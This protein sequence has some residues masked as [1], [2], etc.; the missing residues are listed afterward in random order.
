MINIEPMGSLF[1]PSGI[2]LLKQSVESTGGS[3]GIRW[4]DIRHLGSNLGLE[5]HFFMAGISDYQHVEVIPEQIELRISLHVGSKA[6]KSCNHH[7]GAGN[8]LPRLVR[9]TKLPDY[10]GP[11]LH[12]PGHTGQRIRYPRQQLA[13]RTGGDSL[14][15]PAAKSEVD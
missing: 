15:T 6:A 10:H 8:R 13:R 9:Y 5:E 7:L 14:I 3:R 2:S 4:V 11:G 12:G 1:E